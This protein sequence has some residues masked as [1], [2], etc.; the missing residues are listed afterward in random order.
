MVRVLPFPVTSVAAT[1]HRSFPCA[2]A[3]AAC[4]LLALAALALRGSFDS[5]AE[6]NRTWASGSVGH[7]DYAAA[8][9]IREG[10]FDAIQ[11][12]AQDWTAG[13]VIMP[14]LGNATAKAE[15][16][17]A[18][19]KLLHTMAARF[20]EEPTENERETF[21]S[22][23]FL[24]SRLYPCGECATEFQQLLRKYPPQTSSRGTASMY[25]CHL[26]NLVNARLGKDEFDC[27]EN[28]KD[29]YDCGCGDDPED[30]EEGGGGTAKRGA[31]QSTELERGNEIDGPPAPDETRAPSDPARDS[32][33]GY[34]LVGG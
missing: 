27:G 17:R 16:G 33:T 8:P 21:K 4:V 15:L 31:Q 28:L 14:K 25:L 12:S 11:Q 20:P 18:S 23:L 29:I 1:A 34:E 24:F 9:N 7:R 30:G 6:H 3:L 13:A 22:F 26:H 2:A 19:W 5:P 10:G 32:V